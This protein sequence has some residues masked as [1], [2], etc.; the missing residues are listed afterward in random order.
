MSANDLVVLTQPVGT[1]WVTPSRI[2][3]RCSA[4]RTFRYQNPGCATLH[5]RQGGTKLRRFTSAS[6]RSR[7][8]YRYG[9][10]EAEIRPAKGPGL[11]TGVFL[12]RNSPRQEIDIEFLGRDT[13]QLLVNVYYNP[14]GEGATFEYGYRGTPAAIELDFDA[15]EDFH[16]YSIAWTSSS[17]RWFVDGRMVHER[18]NWNPTPIPHLPMRFFVNLWPP[19]SKQLA[20]VLSPTDLPAKIEIRSV[21]IDVW[22]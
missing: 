19:R 3:L 5:L 18:A 17:L 6:I 11:V 7:G 4:K 2:T 9:R 10:F 12:H 20:G 1:C 16:R 21:D 8:A 13:R 14:G 22:N 15:S